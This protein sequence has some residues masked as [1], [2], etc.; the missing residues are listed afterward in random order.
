MFRLEAG[1]EGAAEEDAA[2]SGSELTYGTV[3]VDLKGAATLGERL[4]FVIR[5]EVRL[6]EVEDFEGGD[7]KSVAVVGEVTALATIVT[8][9]IGGGQVFVEVLIY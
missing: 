5:G 3:V 8:V 1:I 6:G 2:A 4:G 9:R 7:V